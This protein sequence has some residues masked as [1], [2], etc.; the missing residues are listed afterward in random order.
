MA[1]VPVR[2]YYPARSI[3]RRRVLRWIAAIMSKYSRNVSKTNIT[4]FSGQTPTI[5]ECYTKGGEL[6]KGAFGIVSEVTR[7][8]TGE[9]FACKAISKARLA[10]SEDVDDIRKE[11]QI[12]NLVSDHSNIAG[13]NNTYEDDSNVYFI[14][15]LCKGGELFDRIVSEGTFSER[16]AAQYFRI[17]VEVIHHC[18][19]LGVIHRDIKPENFLLTTKGDSAELRT[20][21]FGLSCFFHH[22]EE[23]DSI[24]GSAYYVAPEVLR[25]KYSWQ[26]DLWSLGVILYI[27]LSGMPPFYGDTETQ[28]FKMILKGEVDLQ[29]APWPNIS[30]QA[31][32]LIR[33]LLVQNP[34]KRLTSSEALQHEWLREHQVVSDVPLD[35]VVVTRI[36][37]FAANSRFKKA[38]IGV[39]ANCLSPS[40]LTGLEHLFHSIDQDGNG[41]I[42][43]QEMKQAL[44][45]M[46]NKIPDDQLAE[47]MSVADQNG[48]GTIDWQEFLAA[49]VHI[50]K[51]E[52]DDIIMRAFKKFD[53]NGDGA[54][55]PEEV[56]EVLKDQGLSLDEVHKLIEEHDT[57]KDGSIDYHEFTAMMKG[58]DPERSIS[59]KLAKGRQASRVAKARSLLSGVFRPKSS[60]GS[61]KPKSRF[62]SRIRSRSNTGSDPLK[63][64]F[65]GV[66]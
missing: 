10:S 45:T 12:L 47:L 8:A 61:S 32:D 34:S 52:N 54:I 14:L 59:G 40:E 6:G 23:F 18:H 66:V 65:G 37:Q 17:M 5:W 46:G 15:E 38:A 48:D 1:S 3:Q 13:L 60:D 9:R 22:T 35:S 63:G 49:T 57:N 28:I 36:R 24:V 64:W 27:L 43:A 2:L 56:A 58:A 11:M 39:M 29:S 62:G 16:K 50:N 21:D 41:S 53:R 31:K 55:T 26:A 33:K 7:K 30:S 20:A 4:G 25:R 44:Q 42:S 51:L 19:Q